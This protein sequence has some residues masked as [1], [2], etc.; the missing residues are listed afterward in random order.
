MGPCEGSP[1]CQIKGS[2]LDN[3]KLMHRHPRCLSL[4]HIHAILTLCN[5]TKTCPL[6]TLERIALLGC[7]VVLVMLLYCISLAVVHSGY[8]SPSFNRTLSCLLCLRARAR[9]LWPSLLP[10]FLSHLLLCLH[11]GLALSAFRPFLS[12]PHS[13]RWMDQCT[14]IVRTTDCN[15]RKYWVFLDQRT[16]VQKRFLSD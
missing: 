4:T 14:E 1:I 15:C 7:S 10:R 13:V 5:F 12:L 11:V 16:D 8:L 3:D 2:L 9:S 6:K